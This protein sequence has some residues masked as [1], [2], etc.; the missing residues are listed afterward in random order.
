[1]AIS[2][3][4]PRAVRSMT[5]A[6][7]EERWDPLPTRAFGSARDVAKMVLSLAL[8]VSRFFTAGEFV[9]DNAVTMIPTRTPTPTS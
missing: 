9:I 3:A 5:K 8:P 4:R 1:M 2:V 7:L 6:R